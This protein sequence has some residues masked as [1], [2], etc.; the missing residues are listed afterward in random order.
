MGIYESRSLNL[1][2]VAKNFYKYSLDIMLARNHYMVY[3]CY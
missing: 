3:E 2:M 1:K